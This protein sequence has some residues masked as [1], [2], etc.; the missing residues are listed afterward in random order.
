MLPDCGSGT[1]AAYRGHL[2]NHFANNTV[3]ET[4]VNLLLQCKILTNGLM[5]VIS[6]LS[7]MYKTA[8]E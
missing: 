1:L 6:A 8:S 5:P 4:N 3:E 2:K 7:D